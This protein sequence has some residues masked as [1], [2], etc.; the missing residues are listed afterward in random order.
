MSSGTSILS[1]IPAL[2]RVG[3]II[4]DACLDTDKTNP[5][6]A[7]AVT[8]LDP[9]KLINGSGTPVGGTRAVITAI[10]SIAS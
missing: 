6:P 9:P 3:G 5:T 2:S 1:I 8:K 4:R 10:F 7:I